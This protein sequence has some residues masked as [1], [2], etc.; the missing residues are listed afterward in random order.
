VA[1][2]LS[3]SFSFS[4]AFGA[5]VELEVFPKLPHWAPGKTAPGAPCTSELE[6]DVLGGVSL[7]KML[8][9]GNFGE[10]LFA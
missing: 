3:F 9:A 7:G 4:F 5:F 8:Q 10:F 6:V 2:S 1:S